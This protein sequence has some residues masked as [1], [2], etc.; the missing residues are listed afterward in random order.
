MLTSY[1]MKPK[2]QVSTLLSNAS[3]LQSSGAM[4][5]SDKQKNTNEGKCGNF[6]LLNQSLQ[7]IQ[8]YIDMVPLKDLKRKK[9]QTDT[10]KNLLRRHLVI[11]YATCFLAMQSS[12]PSAGLLHSVASFCP[13]MRMSDFCIISIQICADL[14][15]DQIHPS[16]CLL[17]PKER[18]INI[19]KPK[20][21]HEILPGIK[22]PMYNS[23]PV[24]MQVVDSS[25]KIIL[26]AHSMV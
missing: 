19:S 10:Y 7:G 9:S 6:N 16:D 8:L 18:N 2:A 22:I 5:P 26:S 13:N 3:F 25:V 23:F 24:F 4:Y 21:K 11:L 1:K 17:T 12:R 15:T 14:T 20:C